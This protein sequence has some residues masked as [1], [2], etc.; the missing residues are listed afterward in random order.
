M[1]AC[2]ALAAGVP[3]CASLATVPVPVRGGRARLV[4]RNYPRLAAPGGFVRIQ[5]EGLAH[6]L[7]VLA[8][9]GGAFT[10]LSPVCTHQQC[11]VDV[12]GARLVCP[13]HG[14]E[15][16]RAGAV[17]VGPAERPLP[18]HPAELTAEGELVIDLEAT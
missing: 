5:P 9:E 12:A 15:Y 2:A 11:I 6:H 10:V 16:D 7:V 13:C 14:S 1:S 18:R 8:E 3:A 17:V 4:V